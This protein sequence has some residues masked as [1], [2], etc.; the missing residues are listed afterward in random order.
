MVLRG[1][2]QLTG[3][4]RPP[5]GTPVGATAVIDEDGFIAWVPS[6]GIGAAATHAWQ[7]WTTVVGGVPE[8]V[9]DEDDNLMMIYG[10]L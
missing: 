6:G 1:G 5:A 10:P 2:R 8:F 3:N 7:P 4:E 9:F